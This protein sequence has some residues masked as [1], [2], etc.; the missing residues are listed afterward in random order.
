MQRCI[1]VVV[2]NPDVC[3]SVDQLLDNGGIATQCRAVH[4][5]RAVFMPRV[6]ICPGLNQGVD[7]SAVAIDCCDM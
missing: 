4:G 5:C 1:P 2:P 7:G 6:D 3:A